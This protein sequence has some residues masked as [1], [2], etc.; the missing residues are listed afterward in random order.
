MKK[1]FILGLGLF[2]VTLYGALQ[3]LPVKSVGLR[4]TAKDRLAFMN[5]CYAVR[6]GPKLI[7]R[8]IKVD[9]VAECLVKVAEIESYGYTIIPKSDSRSFKKVTK[10][11]GLE[12]PLPPA[13]TVSR[14]A[15]KVWVEA[16]NRQKFRRP[17]VPFGTN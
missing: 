4:M 5:Q 9:I 17:L 2:L 14:N 8:D 16:S 15:R 7:G 6:Q 1:L 11:K 13:P 3:P 10:K 12:I